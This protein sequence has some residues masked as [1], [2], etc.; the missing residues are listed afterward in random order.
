MSAKITVEA[1]VSPKQTS[2]G[3]V[4]PAVKISIF[5]AAA[6]DSKQFVELLV[7]P[8]VARGLTKYLGLY[9]TGRKI[10]LNMVTGNVNEK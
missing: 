1:V 2:T 4:L 7:T 10:G 8:K 6:P 3:G 5:D 9:L